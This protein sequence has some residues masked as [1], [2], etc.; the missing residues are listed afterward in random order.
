MMS[1]LS[2]EL[3]AC[4]IG[5]GPAASSQRNAIHL[6]PWGIRLSQSLKFGG[7]GLRSQAC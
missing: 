3:N 7:K 2:T 4:L 5:T 1:E 6:G